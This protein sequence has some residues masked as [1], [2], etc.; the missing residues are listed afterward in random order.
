M[1]IDDHYKLKTMR[2]RKIR[3]TKRHINQTDKTEK[4]PLNFIHLRSD[5][6]SFKSMYRCT[7]G[8]KHTRNCLQLMTNCF[9]I[10]L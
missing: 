4:L 1:Y 9:L 8:R 6:E 7:S 10:N 2:M 5:I 3:S